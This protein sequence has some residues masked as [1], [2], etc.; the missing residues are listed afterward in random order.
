[1]TMKYI[2]FLVLIITLAGCSS[3]NTQILKVQLDEVTTRLREVEAANA[4]FRTR[5]HNLETEV[6]VL[7]DRIS[8]MRKRGFRRRNERRYET[9]APANI[10]VQ[11]LEPNTRPVEPE[12]QA[13][14]ESAPPV[15]PQ[16]GL[17]I[18]Y[19]S[20]DDNGDVVTTHS[21]PIKPVSDKSPTPPKTTTATPQSL[22][23]SGFAAY[24]HGEPDKAIEIFERFVNMYPKSELADN[25][26]YWIG[27][28]YYD[29]RDFD[30]AR[31]YFTRVVTQYPKGNKVADAM[32]KLGM[33]NEMQSR[34]D[35]AKRL[36]K[37]VVL[38]Y[39]DSSAAR[40]ASD[41]IR[42]LR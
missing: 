10:P 16:N 11:K 3:N 15:E 32:L 39:P 31:H 40:I 22:Y 42:S 25:A 26:L 21:E 33:C 20:I 4:G 36:F 29:K 23:Q 7:K 13:S 6:E 37:A 27:E 28:C 14:V 19:S 35:E 18:N 24:R 17:S 12:P 38:G 2:V 5:L 8:A 1:M 9:L 41:R 30:K 34:F